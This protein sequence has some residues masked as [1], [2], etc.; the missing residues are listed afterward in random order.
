MCPPASGGCVPCPALNSVLTRPPHPPFSTSQFP[1]QQVDMVMKANNYP[2]TRYTT[3]IE[4]FKAGRK[5]VLVC[6]NALARGLDV[7]AASVVSVSLCV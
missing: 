4:D 1:F 2:G 3:N 7:Q 5:T 6:T